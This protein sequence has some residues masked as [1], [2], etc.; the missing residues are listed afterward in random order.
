MSASM[1][2]SPP[3][4]FRGLTGAALVALT[5]EGLIVLAVVTRLG[6][7][8]T[9]PPP[10]HTV[11][12]EFPVLPTPPAPKP[13]PPPPT[14]P[15]PVPVPP[16]PV[17][18]PPPKPDPVPPPPKP[19]VKPVAAKPRPVRHDPPRHRPHHVHRIVPT[20]LPAPPVAPSLPAPRPTPIPPPRASTPPSTQTAAVSASFES[21]VRSAVQAA[22]R[23]PTAARLM[24]VTGRAKV[25]FTY[26]DGHISGAH[27]LT[28]SG[29]DLIDR[30]AITAVH[31]AQYPAPEADQRHRTLT[32]A[33]WVQFTQD[34]S[35]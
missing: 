29:S 26:L 2:M 28:S 6:A 27:I 16:P 9:Q 10:P 23:Y 22:L 7:P 31:E 12:L 35:N 8:P 5:L 33:I 3:Q 11:M 15:T 24:H 13:T 32:F 4:F 18:L 17:P 20:P 1:T 30:A 21:A 14:P 25:G 34:D 19:V